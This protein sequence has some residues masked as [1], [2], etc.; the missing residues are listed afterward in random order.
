[1]MPKNAAKE[2]VLEDGENNR[3]GGGLQKNRALG[4]IK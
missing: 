1:M 4:R 2:R 3:G